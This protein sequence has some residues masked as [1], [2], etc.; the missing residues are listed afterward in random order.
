[1]LPAP[2]RYPE[3]MLM[4]YS[5]EGFAFALGLGIDLR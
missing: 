3:G 2:R 5:A 4:L 1:M